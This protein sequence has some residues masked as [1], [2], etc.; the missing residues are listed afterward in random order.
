MFF[1]ESSAL[2]ELPEVTFGYL[3]GYFQ[4]DK[5]F[6]VDMRRDIQDHAYIPVLIAVVV[7]RGQGGGGR[8]QCRRTPDEVM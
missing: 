5:V 7:E 3:L 6:L 8:C 1:L 4:A 2:Y